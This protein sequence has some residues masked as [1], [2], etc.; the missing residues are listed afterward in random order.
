M[1]LLVILQQISGI[2]TVG[3]FIQDMVLRFIHRVYTETKIP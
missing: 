1:L 3:G 2:I